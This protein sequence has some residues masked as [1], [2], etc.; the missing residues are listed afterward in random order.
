MDAHKKKQEEEA[1]RE[2]LEKRR[3]KLAK[4]LKEERD[5][6]KVL[7]MFNLYLLFHICRPGNECISLV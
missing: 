2:A 1:K 5:Q 6:F 3:D 4:L 7:I